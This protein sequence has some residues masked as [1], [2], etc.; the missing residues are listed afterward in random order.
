MI[1]LCAFADESSPTLEGQIDALKRNNISLIE[2]RTINDKNV[3]D[4]TKK[5]AK[6]I[7]KTLAKNGIK[8]W[9]LG[10]PVGKID[11]DTDFSEYTKKFIRLLKNAKIFGTD[12]IRMFSFFNAKNKPETVYEKL[13]ILVKIASEHGVSLY[14]ENEKGIFGDTVENVIKLLDNVK[15]LKSVY[16]PANFIQCGE[17]SLYSLKALHSKSGYFHIKDVIKETGELVPAG[18]GDGNIAKLINDIKG[19]RV[20][21]L[22]PHLKVFNAFSK[23][24]D[25][26]LKNKYVFGSNEQAFDFA[27]N[28]LKKLLTENGY[29]E[30][31]GVFAK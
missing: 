30:E 13:S 26:E 24:D 25:T 27:V 29:K 8:V 23:I 7:S 31:K 14:H 12:K 3:F 16:D 6:K 17:D 28:S 21:T 10:S 11:I 2:L 18:E 5:E 15:G 4:L 9:S 20:L 19:D 1:R 22:E